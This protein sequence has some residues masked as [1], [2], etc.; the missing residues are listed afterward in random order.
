MTEWTSTCARTRSAFGQDVAM[1]LSKR[2]FESSNARQE[3]LDGSFAE[4]VR[5]AGRVLARATFLPG[6]QWSQHVK[7][8]AR[9]ESCQ[10]AHVGYVM[11]GAFRVVMDDGTSEEFG[12]GDLYAIP[13]GHDTEI[14]GGERCTL[15]DVSASRTDA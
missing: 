11:T 13:P 15:L 14:I 3:Y 8:L 7:P 2:R 6:H 10:E 4:V 12:P 1:E 9:T 5:I